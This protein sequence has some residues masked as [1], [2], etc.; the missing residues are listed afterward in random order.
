MVDVK[1]HGFAVLLLLVSE[2]N[3]Q[4]GCVSIVG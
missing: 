4:A 2:M 1:S 3:R